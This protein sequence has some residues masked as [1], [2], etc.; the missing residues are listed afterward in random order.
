LIGF[1]LIAVAAQ[2]VDR[3]SVP[4]DVQASLDRNCV[5][6]HGPLEQNAGLRLDSAAGLSRGS[7]DGPVVNLGNPESRKLVQVLAPGADPHMPPKKQLPDHDI[8]SLRAWITAAVSQP[9]PT[10]P[11]SDELIPADPSAAIDHFLSV[12]WQARGLT[13]APVCDD[14]TFL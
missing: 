2:A 7:D 8:S 10:L 1:L 14:R 13:P 11:S 12:A 9:N 5:K 4:A 3:V 6:C